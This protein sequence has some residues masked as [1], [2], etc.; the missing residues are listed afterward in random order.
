MLFTGVHI[1]H[2]FAAPAADI[3]APHKLALAALDVP[4]HMG[5]VASAAAEQV[6]AVRAGG[7]A[8]AAAPP[9]TRNA[10]PLVLQAV[11][12][13]LVQVDKLVFVERSVLV[14]PPGLLP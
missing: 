13:R 12:G 6:A 2:A 8:V 7:C 1:V 3:A 9:G 5:I 10:P 14:L 11:V 4:H